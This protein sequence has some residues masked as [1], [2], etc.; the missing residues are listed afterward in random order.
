MKAHP[1]KIGWTRWQPMVTL[2]LGLWI[3]VSPWILGFAATANAAWTYYLVGALVTIF[4]AIALIGGRGPAPHW[5]VG[6]FAAWFAG[7]PWMLN[8]ATLNVAAATAV[9][10]GIVTAVLAIWALVLDARRPHA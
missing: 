1:A 10:T 4:S 8:Y 9:V 7:S 5:V 3:I 2:V 6:L